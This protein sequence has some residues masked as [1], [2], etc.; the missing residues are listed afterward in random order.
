MMNRIT[1]AVQLGPG[2]TKREIKTL[3]KTIKSTR[4]LNKSN[5]QADATLELIEL[6][7]D[8]AIAIKL[9]NDVYMPSAPV[10]DDDDGT[11][12][13]YA[14]AVQDIED[15]K[16]K[17]KEMVDAFDEG[18]VPKSKKIKRLRTKLKNVFSD[19]GLY[20]K[21]IENAKEEKK[22]D[23]NDEISDLFKGMHM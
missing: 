18:I 1:A 17:I 3:A 7:N 13:A 12:D 8:V 5:A 14:A 21:D 2:A 16:Y 19:F 15:I 22:F 11:L 6:Y 23:V 9:F 4:K 20:Y 10:D